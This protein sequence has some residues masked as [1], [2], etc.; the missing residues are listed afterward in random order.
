MAHT[1]VSDAL[2]RAHADALLS[3]GLAGYSCLNIDD[4]WNRNSKSTDPAVNDPGRDDNGNL[5]TS[6]NSPD[7][8]GLTDYLQGEGLKAVSTHLPGHG[9]ALATR[10]ATNTSSKMHVC[11]QCGL[12]FSKI[13][14]VLI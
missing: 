6:A 5:R 2:I 13:R 10:V 8:K 1:D 3:T 14:F 12:R 9:R 7:M 11:S 4:G